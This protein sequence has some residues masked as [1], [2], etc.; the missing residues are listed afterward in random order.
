MTK[1]NIHKLLVTSTVARKVTITQAG[2]KFDEGLIYADEWLSVVAI[3]RLQSNNNYL[4]N[5]EKYANH[6]SLYTYLN[7]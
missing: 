1:S 4:N 2:D 3:A 7:I 6:G 5:M